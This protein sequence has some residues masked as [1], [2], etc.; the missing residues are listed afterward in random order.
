MA[1]KA[2]K[3]PT[4]RTGVKLPPLSKPWSELTQE[5]REARVDAAHGI[6]AGLISSEEFMREK[7]EEIEREEERFQ[8]RYKK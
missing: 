2:T 7:H 8:R 1:T 5:E 3:L 4:K 6:F